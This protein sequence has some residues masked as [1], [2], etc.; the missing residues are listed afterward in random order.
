MQLQLCFKE[1]L[2]GAGCPC[3][4]VPLLGPCATS[5]ATHSAE[6]LMPSSYP[7]LS[8]AL[9]FSVQVSGQKPLAVLSSL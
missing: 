5:V 7:V 3:S 8:M 1:K 6:A 2:S 9:Q 4:L